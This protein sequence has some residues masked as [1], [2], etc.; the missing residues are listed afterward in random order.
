[1]MTMRRYFFTFLIICLTFIAKADDQKPSII[2][3]I[4]ASGNI[5]VEAP[6]ELNSRLTQDADDQVSDGTTQRSQTYV[7]SVGF[8]V[9]I[10]AGNNARTAKS[11]ASARRRNVSSRF[12]QYNAYLVFESPYWRVR[13]GD[14]HSRPEAEAALA[15]IRRAFPSYG[16][17]LR[18]VRA[19]INKN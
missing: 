4:N 1:M 6:D 15:E 5:T 13:V 16:K 2:N 7:S 9:E 8:R 19:R 12:P 10:F 17:D 3:H 14:F 18:I 11:Q